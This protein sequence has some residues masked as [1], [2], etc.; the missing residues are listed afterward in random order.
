MPV[1]PGFH[2]VEHDAQKLAKRQEL[3]GVEKRFPRVAPQ[4][5]QI[6]PVQP[7]NH[8]SESNPPPENGPQIKS[9]E[10]KPPETPV[11]PGGT[12]PTH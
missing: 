2:A 3:E 4:P 11:A 5:E 12:Q 6:A 9:L 8:E 7:E 10:N 1:V